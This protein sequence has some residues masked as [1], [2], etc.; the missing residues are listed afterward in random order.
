MPLITCPECGRQISTAA[1]ACPQCGHPNRPVAPERVESGPRCY[2]CNATATTRC[3]SCGRLS[4]ALHL[5]SIFVSH[6][7]G[8]GYE[9]RC[10]SCHASAMTWKIVGYVFVG[11]V[12]IIMLAVM[13]QIGR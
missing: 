4:C 12:L 5:E 2:A 3:Q 11:I 9:L 13:T 1:E 7:R 6:G 10:E 8:G